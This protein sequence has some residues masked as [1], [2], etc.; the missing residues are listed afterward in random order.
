MPILKVEAD[1]ISNDSLQ[2][3][4]VEVIIERGARELLQYLP[5]KGFEGRAYA[6]N[7]EKTLPTG[8]SA[9]DPYGTTALP[10][11]VGTRER[12]SVET[13]M[14]SR[15][16]D[17]A[18]IDVIGKSDVNDARYQDTVLAA[19][20]L[21]ADFMEQFISGKGSRWNMRGLEYWGD[22]YPTVNA[23]YGDMLVYN[24]NT[25]L[26]SGTKAALALTDLDNLLSLY[27]GDRFQMIASDRQTYVAYRNL[28]IAA[29]GNIA[30]MFMKNNFGESIPAYDGI[31]WLILDPVGQAKAGADADYD[32]TGGA[33]ERLMTVD[34]TS[35]P[36]WIGFSSLDVGRQV[37][38]SGAATGTI[39]TIVS[40]TAV[41]F[42]TG[43][44]PGSDVSAESFTVAKTN[45]IYALR[46][47]EQDG[48]T[49]VNHSNQ[50]GAAAPTGDYYGPIGG[51]DAEDLGI[52]EGLNNYRTRL[53]WFGNIVNH[54]PH[55]MARLS[56]YTI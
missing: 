7:M 18:K 54:N 13:G 25:G 37:T 15:N 28:L 17:T 46:F 8:S 45:A 55:A 49:A 21:A 39:E 1:K 27:K 35:D 36:Y 3:G 51:F 44:N 11:G 56:H 40:E 9:R 48:V 23:D 5:F 22:Y 24:T 10:D 4:V 30:N 12:I 32:H 47:D 31:P 38:F 52:L 50:G 29:G 42:T 43:D 53:S 20:K 16:A 26:S 19:K 34:V 6:F 2:K 33:S 41:T 14:L